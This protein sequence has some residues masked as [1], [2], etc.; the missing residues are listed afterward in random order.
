MRYIVYDN[1]GKILWCGTNKWG[2]APKSRP[3]KNVI[4]GVADGRT[5]K[6]INRKIVP[7][8]LEEMNNDNPLP[9]TPISIGNRNAYV[10]QDQYQSILDRLDALENPVQ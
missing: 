4:E 3:D 10:T 5:H 9:D 7:R 6:I 1:N 8:T 2:K